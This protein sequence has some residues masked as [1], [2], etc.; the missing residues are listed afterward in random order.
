MYP[1]TDSIRQ[2]IEDARSVG[3]IALHRTPH[4]PDDQNAS[5]IKQKAHTLRMLQG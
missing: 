5:T 3:N 1:Q 4:V 2:V